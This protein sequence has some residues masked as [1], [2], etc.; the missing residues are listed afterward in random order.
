MFLYDMDF[1]GGS[2]SKESVY[3]AGDLGSIPG[4]GRFPGEG[5]GYLL[6]YFSLENSMDFIVHG[7]AKS[8]TQMSYFH[9]YFGQVRCILSQK[10]WLMGSNPFQPLRIQRRCKTLW[11]F[12]V[13]RTY[14]PHLAQCLHLL[15]CLVKEGMKAGG[16]GD[17]RGRD[18]WMAS[19]TQRT[20][21]GASS[22]SWW[23]TGKPGVLQFTGRKDSDTTERLNWK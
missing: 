17:N 18:G 3:N 12:E 4:L 1:P 8:R 15:Y 2:D 7:V 23:W 6:Q 20:W 21:I 14:I 13:W 22:R 10:L 19:P 9:F 11:G 5:N 16:E